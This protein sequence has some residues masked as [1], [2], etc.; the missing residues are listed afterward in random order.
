V[1]V[2]AGTRVSL[3]GLPIFGGFDDKTRG[4]GELLPDAPEL[5]VA[6]TAIFGG[7]SVKNFPDQR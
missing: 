3:S 1:I 5:T 4:E 2:P 6:A 7:V